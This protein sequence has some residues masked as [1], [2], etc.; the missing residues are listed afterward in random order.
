MR[1][2]FN[3]LTCIG[4]CLIFPEAPGLNQTMEPE[5]IFLYADL[6]VGAQKKSTPKK[7][8]NYYATYSR[9]TYRKFWECDLQ[10]GTIMQ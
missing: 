10:E 3:N 7:S 6:F 2:E 1:Q 8:A 9:I 4:H 5:L